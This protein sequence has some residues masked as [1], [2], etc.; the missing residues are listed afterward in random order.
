MKKNQV[1]EEI[2]IVLHLYIVQGHA[3]PSALLFRDTYTE[4]K[5]KRLVIL[6]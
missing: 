4:S 2:H 6:L 3:Q 1:A 5:L